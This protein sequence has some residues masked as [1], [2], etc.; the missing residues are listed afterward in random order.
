MVDHLSN[1][2]EEQAREVADHS[3]PAAKVVHAAAPLEWTPSLDADPWFG[4][5]TR[6]L[7]WAPVRM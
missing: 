1:L 5:I 4:R 7:G 6:R 3:P 2:P